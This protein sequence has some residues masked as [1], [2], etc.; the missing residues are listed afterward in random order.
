[1]ENVSCDW[2][3]LNIVIHDIWEWLKPRL[4]MANDWR[5]TGCKLQQ[6][7]WL[8]IVCQ[9][10]LLKNL[11]HCDHWCW[12]R[13]YTEGYWSWESCWKSP[14][15][16]WPWIFEFPLFRTIS[17]WSGWFV[18]VNAIMIIVHGNSLMVTTSIFVI[19]FV[20]N[21]R[22]ISSPRLGTP[23]FGTATVGFLQCFMTQPARNRNGWPQYHG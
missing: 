14:W 13:C 18:M 15:F 9:K 11:L 19:H 8:I 1:M 17:W 5:S 20:R 2:R 7:E 10:C 16:S 4:V 21:C 3:W 22:I 12:K 23:S 6:G